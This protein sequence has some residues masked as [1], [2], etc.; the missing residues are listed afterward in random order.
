MK[1]DS[2]W[3]YETE[4]YKITVG[5]HTMST[6]PNKLKGA[7]IELLKK[8]PFLNHLECYSHS[9]EENGA[10]DYDCSFSFYIDEIDEIREEQPHLFV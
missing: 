3:T 2:E 7:I 6:Y 9:I 5:G 1:I 10:E 8:H 4:T